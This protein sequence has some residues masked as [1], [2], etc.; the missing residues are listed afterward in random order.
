MGVYIGVR[1]EIKDL[2]VDGT[3]VPSV[4]T[5]RRLHGRPEFSPAGAAVRH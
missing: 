3:N 1:R 2:L 4:T 5:Q